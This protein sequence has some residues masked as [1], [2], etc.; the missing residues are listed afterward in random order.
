MFQENMGNEYIVMQGGTSEGTQIKYRKGKY[1]YKK[2]RQGNEG[3]V[4]YLVSHLLT[5]STL[6]QSEY[7]LYEQGIINRLSGCRSENFL[8][9]EE[10]LITFYRLYYN[11][12]GKDLSRVIS[13]M[14]SMEER[15]VYVLQFI[16]ASCGLD[17]ADYLR[18]I[19]TLDMLTLNE[20]RHLN[21]LA[22]ILRGHE[23][24]PAPIF[25]NGVSL[26]TANRSVNWHFSMEENVR[27]V[28]ARPFSGSHENMYQYFGTGFQLDYPAVYEWLAGEEKSRERDVLEYQ[29]RRY[30]HVLRRES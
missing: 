14:D 1:W 21:N 5:F 26:L 11:E 25:D 9:E 15:I 6:E 12:Y 17:V 29:I 16:K 27:R 3:R 22:V 19:F 23:F 4:E 10:E 8:Q 13:A 20:D 30:E 2:D 18:K 7:V 24:I 28:I